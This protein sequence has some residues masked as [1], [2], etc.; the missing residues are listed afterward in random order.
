MNDKVKFNIYHNALTAYAKTAYAKTI[1]PTCIK[2]LI[3]LKTGNFLEH[4]VN[5]VEEIG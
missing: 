2:A 4:F 3:V 5:C 1:L